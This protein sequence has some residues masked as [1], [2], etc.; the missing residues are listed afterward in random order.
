MAS[1]AF[2]GLGA[3]GS[4]MV[5]H[6]LGAGHE[7]TVWNRSPEK[8]KVLCE[9][10][11]SVAASPRAAVMTA[12]FVI[13]MVRD[14]IASQFVWLDEASGA[15]AA[16][17]STSI[18]IECSTLSLDWVRR[19]GALCNDVSCGFIDAP[20]AGSRPQ[21]EQ[22]KLIFL[23]GGELWAVGQATP[24]LSAMGGAVHHAGPVGAGA[25]VKLAVN[26]LLGVQVAALA[27]LL[28]MIRQQ[29]YAASRAAD[30]IGA[31][32]IASAAARAAAGAMLASDFAPLFP[33]EMVE[34]DFGYALAAA[35]PTG[36]APM[37][38]AARSVFQKAVDVGFGADNLTGIVR[39]YGEDQS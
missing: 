38:S 16:L 37:M 32:P 21:A 39:L 6:L 13:S 11:A 29:G 2:L 23:V 12:Q 34:K 25:A 4:R 3:M 27:E 19:L 31:T 24:I 8:T 9:A 35:G 10:G 1:I 28:G 20:V 36:Q 22:R 7:V 5:T 30:I 18:A 15:L 14:D 26:G 17:S 33:V